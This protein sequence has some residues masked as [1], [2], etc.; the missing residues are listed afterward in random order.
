M[1]YIY[2]IYVLYMYYYEPSSTYRI[3]VDIGYDAN[4][5]KRVGNK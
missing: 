4:T 3:P 5:A 1:Y 2:T